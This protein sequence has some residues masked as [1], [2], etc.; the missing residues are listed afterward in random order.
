MKPFKD[1]TGRGWSIDV[2]FASLKRVK[3]LVRHDLLDPKDLERVCNSV[4]DVADVLYC[5][6]KPQ[7][8]EREITDEQFGALLIDV[9]EAASTALFED[10]SDFFRRLGRKALASLIQKMM[11]WTRAELTKGEQVLEA[12]E[13]TGKM[14]RA[15][16]AAMTRAEKTVHRRLDRLIGGKTAIG[17]QGS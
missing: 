17:S 14:D 4:S 7:C 2:S 15:I 13:Q 8:D 11:K 16:E 6:C 5:V 9:F 12:I 3:E 10:L 1:A